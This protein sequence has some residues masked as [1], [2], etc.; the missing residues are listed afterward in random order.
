LLTTVFVCGC[1][2][3][4]DLSVGGKVT[5]PME[6]RGEIGRG[7]HRARAHDEPQLGRIEVLQVR[8]RKH[9]GISGDPAADQV[10]VA[11]KKYPLVAK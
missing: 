7:L 11:M 1:D 6:M 9:A 2:G 4:D 8:R 10:S 5:A 3:V